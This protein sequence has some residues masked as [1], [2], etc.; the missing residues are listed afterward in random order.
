MASSDVPGAEN[1]GSD[2][3]HLLEQS[4]VTREIQEAFYKAGIDSV[5]NFAALVEKVEDLR[6][7][8]KVEFRIDPA[9]SLAERVK[10][11]NVVVAWNSAKTRAAKV[12]ELDGEAEIRGEA[13]KIPMP[14][15]VAM[16]E[17]FEKQFWKLEDHEVPSKTL[18]E[19]R[20]DMI[21]KGD[22]KA[23]PL[24]EVLDLEVD[25]GND[26]LPVWDS[27]VYKAMRVATKIPLPSNTEQLRRRLAVWGHSWVFAKYL[28]TTRS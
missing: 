9:T 7:L 19:K 18:I 24:E 13:K 8:M 2:L 12:A 10:V 16:R 14:D 20:L 1:V 23:E 21:E 15:F 25:E 3:V 4:K 26:S 17:A 27:G 6:E 28:H 11:S 5:K 22:F